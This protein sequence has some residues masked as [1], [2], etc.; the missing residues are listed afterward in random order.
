MKYN[1]DEVNLNSVNDL[2]DK[3]REAKMKML[4]NGIT[5]IIFNTSKENIQ[6]IH[7]YYQS[8]LGFHEISGV[9]GMRLNVVDL[10]KDITFILTEDKELVRLKEV[11]RKYKAIEQRL[12]GYLA[13][14]DIEAHDLIT[15]LLEFV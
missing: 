15:E 3:V 11:E 9:Y 2:I 14:R 7:E 5:D 4:E 8:E 12:A 1:F 13:G 10:P 6:Y